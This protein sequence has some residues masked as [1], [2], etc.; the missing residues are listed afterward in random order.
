VYEPL[1]S[2]AEVAEIQ[3]VARGQFNTPVLIFRPGQIAAS[4][5]EY[6]PSYDYGDS[7]L[8][9]PVY[10]YF[11]GGSSSAAVEQPDDVLA[12][13]GSFSVWF[14]S[15]LQPELIAGE[16]QIGTISLHIVRAP[17]GSD[18][19]ED[20]IMRVIDSGQEYVVTDT[21]K[22]DSWPEMMKMIVRSRE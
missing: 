7:G 9:D 5:P 14:L 10:D 8:T 22:D 2:P 18:I 1:L 11:D 12:A 20:D 21:N 3:G 16:S 17:V 13:D 15:R 19:V 6:N 4:S